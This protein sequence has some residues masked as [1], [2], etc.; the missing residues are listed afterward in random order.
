MKRSWRARFIVGT[1]I[2]LWPGMGIAH[3]RDHEDR[4]R[5]HDRARELVRAGEIL[6]LERI[7]EHDPRARGRRILEVELENKHGRWIYEIE[8]K[9]EGGRVMELEF[10][11]R[12]GQL[13]REHEEKPKRATAGGGR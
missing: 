1:L 13:L 10:D 7:L 12:T 2:W 4:H 11:A 5:D 9:D 3:S 8:V 6:P